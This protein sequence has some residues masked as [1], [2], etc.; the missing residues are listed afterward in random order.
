MAKAKVPTVQVPADRVVQVTSNHGG[1]W[2]G[3]CT[4]CDAVGWLDGRHGWKH[5]SDCMSNRLIH[6]KSCP[7]NAVLDGDKLVSK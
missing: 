3:E 7:M 1:Y 5:G 6:K 2:A 4:L